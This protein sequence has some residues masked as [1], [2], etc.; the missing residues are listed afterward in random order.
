[1]KYMTLDTDETAALNLYRKLGFK[2]YG[3]SAGYVK[4]FNQ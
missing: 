1:M 3:E 4:K 2:E